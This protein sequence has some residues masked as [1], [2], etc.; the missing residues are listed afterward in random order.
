MTPCRKSR[1]ISPN[2]RQRQRRVTLEALR[3]A[4]ADAGL[5]ISEL[6]KRA[7]VSRDTVSNAERGLHSLQATTLHKVA[8]ALGKAPSEL[9]AEEERLTPKALSS[10]PEPTFDDVLD[11]EQRLALI[12]NL[13]DEIRHFAARWHDELKNAQSQ[14]R[15]W[16]GGVQVLATGYTDIILRRDL[17]RKVKGIGK[18]S[19]EEQHQT[20]IENQSDPEFLAA[21]KLMEAWAYMSKAADK[22]DEAASDLWGAW[23]VREEAEQRRKAFSVIQGDLSA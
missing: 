18:L 9:L 23:G 17:L 21:M 6:A 22:V 8:H 2:V 19:K 12:K 11:D 15:Y 4:R 14:D 7:G 10:S 13:E 1:K 20:F 16:H 5:T 3:R